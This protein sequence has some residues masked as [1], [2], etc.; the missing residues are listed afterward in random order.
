MYSFIEAEK[1]EERSVDRSC[2][3]LEA[4]RAAYYEWRTQ[5]PSQREREDQELGERVK[6]VRLLSADLRGTRSASG[7]AAT[8][9]EVL[10]QAGGAADAGA[11]PGGQV[12]QAVEED[13][14]AR[15]GPAGR[16]PGRASIP[17]W[18]LAVNSCWAGDITQVRTGKAGCTWRR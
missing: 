9:G 2:A 13:H 12:P 3:V 15:S 5:R 14:R 18:V 7:A 17:A 4:S 11:G 1:A 6:V 16:G 8:G 10:A